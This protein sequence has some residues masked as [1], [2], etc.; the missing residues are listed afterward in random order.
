LISHL[1][2]D[3]IT[4]DADWRDG[5]DAYMNKQKLEINALRIEIDYLSNELK[6]IRVEV[7]DAIDKCLNIKKLQDQQI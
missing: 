1:D 4:R 2:R 3:K 6:N 7:K 5:V